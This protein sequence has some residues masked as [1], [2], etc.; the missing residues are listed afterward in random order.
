MT[1]QDKPSGITQ[2]ETDEKS[3]LIPMY[4]VI[5][6]NDDVTPMDF[7]VTVLLRFFIS[8]R[9]KAYEIMMTA[10]RE[11]AAT[12]A[13]MPLERAEFKVTRAHD[14]IRAQ[15]QPLTFSIEPCE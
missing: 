6:H 3:L 14:F 8:V 5:L 2:E 11:G 9:E 15:D 1:E 7:V 13:V 10:H 4:R 12:V